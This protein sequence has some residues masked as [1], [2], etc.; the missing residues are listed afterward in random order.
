VASYRLGDLA[1]QVGGK[2]RGNPDRTVRGVATLDQAGPDELSFLTN[3]RY[4]R[5]ARSSNAGAI[6]V[7]PGVELEGFD[8]VEAA[9]PYLA[10]AQLLERFHPRVT[11]APGV[12]PD[13]RVGREVRMGRDVHVGPF[14]VVGD[15]C[16]LG[17]RACVGAACVLGQACRVGNDSE[18]KPHVVLYDGTEIGERCIIHSGVVL[19]GDGFGFASSG[20]KHRKVPQVGRV[21]VEDDVEIGANSVVDRAMLGE[22]RIGEGTKVDDLVM[23]AHGVRLGRNSLLVGQSG[24][25]GSSRLG[26]G[27]TIAGQSGVAGHLELGEGVTVAAKSAVFQDLPAKAFV[28]GVP[29]TD[30][31][32]WIRSQ[33]LVRKLPELRKELRKELRE[34]RARLVTLEQRL[35]GEG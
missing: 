26:A 1:Q 17:D 31:K 5:A 15:G 21:V 25:A 3:S 9:E 2:V 11:A 8:L 10:L 20:G 12:S 16:E 6:L 33:S 13:A 34:L 29:A 24:V 18:L 23:I 4:M 28:A 22:T 32:V 7:G 27:T 35:P 19:G 30:H 14:A